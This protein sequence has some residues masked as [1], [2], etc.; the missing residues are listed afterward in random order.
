VFLQ[1]DA[2]ARVVGAALRIGSSGTLLN[3]TEDVRRW[4]NR[5]YDRLVAVDENKSTHETVRNQQF[6]Q[7]VTGLSATR[8]EFAMPPPAVAQPTHETAVVALGAGQA[9]RVWPVEKLASLLRHLFKAHPTLRVVLLGVGSDRPMAK[10]LEELVGVRLDS[11][12]GETTL[13][14]Y[15]ATIGRARLVICNDSS[16][17]HVAMAYRRHVLCLLGGGHYGWFAPYPA[18]D[19]DRAV[20][21]R[22]PM[23]CFWC[24][25]ECRYPRAPQGA[26]RCVASIA[27]E[28]AVASVDLLLAV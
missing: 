15:V 27:V 8:F 24:N 11:R 21:L 22:V 7:G 28:D 2:I 1:E 23:E 5:F 12:V 20:V 16:A 14:E 10:R 25:W 6:V 26:F 17:Y 13:E 3:M 19:S 18:A 4:G 9:G